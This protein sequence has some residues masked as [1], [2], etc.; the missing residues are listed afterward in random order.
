[1]N[2]FIFSNFDQTSRGENAGTLQE[3]IIDGTKAMTSALTLD[4]V[5][6]L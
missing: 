5:M 4:E 2:F 1:M 3:R 6:W